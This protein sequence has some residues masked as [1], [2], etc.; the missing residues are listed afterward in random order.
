MLSRV[1]WSAVLV[2]TNQPTS[3]VKLSL[4]FLF[5]ESGLDLWLALTNR[6]SSGDVLTP[7]PRL[8]PSRFRSLQFGSPKLAQNEPGSAATQDLW[9]ES[10]P[11]TPWGLKLSHPAR[12]PTN[13][14]G[15][16]SHTATISK[17]SGRDAQ[18]SKDHEPPF[19]SRDY[20]ALC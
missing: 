14:P 11:K 10:G 13:Q 15:E 4:S 1:R 19:V 12:S 16:R 8:Q 5:F 3:W 17:N 18:P 7:K 2:T 20:R 6:Y 9:T